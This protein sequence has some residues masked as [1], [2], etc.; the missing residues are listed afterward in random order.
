VDA[1]DSDKDDTEII[2]TVKSFIEKA[3]GPSV[4]N[5]YLCNLQIF[6]ISQGLSRQAFILNVLFASK[7]EAYPQTID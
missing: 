5:I 3:L 6:E 1:T 4:V 2:T 7:V